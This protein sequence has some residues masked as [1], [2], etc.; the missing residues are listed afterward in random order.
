[1]KKETIRRA[2]RSRYG[3]I[4]AGQ[5]GSDSEAE[6]VTMDVVEG[7][8]EASCCGPSCCSPEGGQT[9]FADIAQD[10]GYGEADVA[11]VP[12]GANMGL[13]CG[14]PIALASLEPG[15]TVLDLGSGGGFDCFL[16][17]DRVGTAG[18]VIGVDMTPDMIEL[19]RRNAEKGGYD[20]VEFRL[21]EIEALPVADGTVDA[22]ISNCVINLSADPERVF[23][24]AHR[25]L[26]PGGRLMISDLVSESEVPEILVENPDAF[27]TCLPVHRSTYLER[28]R[29][30]GF[31]QVEV[32]RE[33]R[34]ATD[35][36]QADSAIG[37]L[38]RDA[39]I[40]PAVIET[41]IDGIRSA[42]IT[43]V[44]AEAAP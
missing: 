44:K 12:D 3:A 2:V 21:G 4:A 22:I 24:E 8:V 11:S 43:A 17:A 5:L 6:T 42:G 10:I 34:F 9:S 16:A 26:K 33:D 37:R 15:E 31:E 19:S 20:N 41:F 39:G 35:H 28:M 25:V 38:V 29:A 40:D 23:R 30:A 13:G 18:S 36:L 32:V 1:M 27:V 14:N 7:G